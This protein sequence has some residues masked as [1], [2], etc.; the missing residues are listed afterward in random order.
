V[1]SYRKEKDYADEKAAIKLRGTT[2]KKA[3]TDT[4]FIREFEYGQNQEG[5]CKNLGKKG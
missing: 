3:L 4:P 5:Y 2:K 1:N